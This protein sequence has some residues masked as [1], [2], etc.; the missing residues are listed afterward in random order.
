MMGAKRWK[1]R[2]IKC[3]VLSETN[4][5]TNNKKNLF[6]LLLLQ[7]YVMQLSSSVYLTYS[8]SALVFFQWCLLGGKR[9]KGTE[10]ILFLPPSPQDVKWMAAKPATC[11]CLFHTGMTRCAVATLHH[12]SECVSAFTLCSAV[13]PV[14]QAGISTHFSSHTDSSYTHVPTESWQCMQLCACTSA[15]AP[16][17]HS[18]TINGPFQVNCLT[19]YGI[20]QYTFYLFAHWWDCIYCMRTCGSVNNHIELWLPQTLEDVAPNFCWELY[21]YFE[22]IT[23][24]IERRSHRAS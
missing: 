12:T 10:K 16:S 7:S 19:T 2:E 23:S 1:E 21:I 22:I 24:F 4:K 13:C 9:K 18:T 5:E 17:V 14:R 15:Q 8:C 20:S 11:N 3:K 6:S